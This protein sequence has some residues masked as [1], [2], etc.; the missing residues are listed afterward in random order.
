M[1][2]EE[3]GGGRRRTRVWKG[4]RQARCRSGMEAK[5]ERVGSTVPT[6]LHAHLYMGEKSSDIRAGLVM[7]LAG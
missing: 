1:V 2:G 7:G 3:G 5:K 6:G 4:G